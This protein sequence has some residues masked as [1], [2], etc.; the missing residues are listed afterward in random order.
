MNKPHTSPQE[1]LWAAVES[2]SLEEARAAVASGADVNAADEY[3]ETPLT[4]SVSVGE[5]AQT[6]TKLV[7][8]LLSQG[9]LV[10][11]ERSKAGLGTSV[12]R[13]ARSGSVEVLRVLLNKDG[14]VALSQFDE[15]GLT[16][17]SASVLNDS[18]EAARL[19]I[20]ARSPINLRDEE[21]LGD[22]AL[23]HAV[24]NHNVEMVK[25]LLNAGADPLMPGYLHHTPLYVAQYEDDDEQTPAT[26]QIRKLL[27]EH[28][29]GRTSS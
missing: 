28:A 24:R 29:A 20:D 21:E 22:P 3:G 11:K 18:L 16:P 7:E 4:G 12:H 23:T 6:S 13:A 19:L 17:L 8:Y 14:H 1:R 9:A 15:L 26:R 10:A 25:L 2:G 5:G 27:E